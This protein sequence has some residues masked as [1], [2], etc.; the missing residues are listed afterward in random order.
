VR[1]VVLLALFAGGC[2]HHDLHVPGWRCHSEAHLCECQRLGARHPVDPSWTDESCPSREE[3][4]SCWASYGMGEKGP[5][6]CVCTTHF[7]KG[8]GDEHVAQCPPPL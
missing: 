1:A 8:D 4:L 7:K 2:K 5:G 3:P 6:Y